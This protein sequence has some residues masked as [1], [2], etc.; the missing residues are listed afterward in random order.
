[1]KSDLNNNNIESELIR[2]IAQRDLGLKESFDPPKKIILDNSE[3]GE[4][5]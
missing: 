3:I 5:N 4:I 2:I 1:M